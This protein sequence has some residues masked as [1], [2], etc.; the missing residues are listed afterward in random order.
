MINQPVQHLKLNK[1]CERLIFSLFAIQ[2]LI[3]CSLFVHF[4]QFP[5]FVAQCSLNLVEYGSI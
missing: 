2:N 4:D 5:I 3:L 1:F